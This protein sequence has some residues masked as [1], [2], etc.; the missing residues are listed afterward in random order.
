MIIK[1]TLL[2]L[3]F[4]TFVFAKP[5]AYFYKISGNPN[6]FAVFGSVAISIQEDQNSITTTVYEFQPISFL[7]LLRNSLQTGIQVLD[8]KANSP[9][10]IEKSTFEQKSKIP[11][12]LKNRYHNQQIKKA[13]LN[14]TKTQLQQLLAY[15]ENSHNQETGFFKRNPVAKMRDALFTALKLEPN[16]HQTAL[17]YKKLLIESMGSHAIALIPQEYEK[18]PKVL[19]ISTAFKHQKIPLTI[20]SEK[21]LNEALQKIIRF[22]QLSSEVFIGLKPIIPKL[23]HYLSTNLDEPLDESRAL[24]TSDRLFAALQNIENPKNRNHLIVKP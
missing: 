16:T 15:L 2:F 6:F 21:D 19:Q 13:K 10:L 23:T 7:R 20:N 14:L 22:A 1:K 11:I 17:T 5:V 12:V 18:N 9:L 24:I 4:P 3:L 8:E